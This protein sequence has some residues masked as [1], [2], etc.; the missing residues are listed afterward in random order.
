MSRK[1]FNAIGPKGILLL[2]KS[3]LRGMVLIVI[4]RSF[5]VMGLVLGPYPE[6]SHIYGSW[7]GAWAFKK[8]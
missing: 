4:Q 5:E 6:D 7:C 8:Y 3:I 2:A 1:L